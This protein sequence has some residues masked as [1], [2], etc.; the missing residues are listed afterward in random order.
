MLAAYKRK[1][2]ILL[3]AQQRHCYEPLSDLD[4]TVTP[5]KIQMR[6]DLLLLGRYKQRFT[7]SFLLPKQLQINISHYQKNVFNFNEQIHIKVVFLSTDKE[8]IYIVIQTHK[9]YTE[10][11]HS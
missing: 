7:Q 2:K 3:P 4:Y 9:C 11:P 8:A 1:G 10:V 5:C 6:Q